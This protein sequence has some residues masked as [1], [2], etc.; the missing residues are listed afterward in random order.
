MKIHKGDIVK[1][2]AGRDRGKSGKV[3]EAFPKKERVLVEGVNKVKKHERPRKANQKGQV[4]ERA[5]PIHIS[6]VALVKKK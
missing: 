6:N 1:I 4:V 3:L 5:M 2:L